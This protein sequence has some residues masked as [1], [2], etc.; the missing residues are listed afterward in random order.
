MLGID[1]PGIY[2][3][4]LLAILGLIVSVVYGAL[5]WNKGKETEIEEI[6]KDLEW[7]IKDEHAKN[8]IS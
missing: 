5:N 1:D 7:E 3:G 2:L 8:E 4:Y 6:E